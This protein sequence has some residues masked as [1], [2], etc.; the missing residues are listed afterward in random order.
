EYLTVE[1][2]ETKAVHDGT[3][4]LELA[5]SGDYDMAVLD[6]MLPKM[7]GFDVLRNLRGSSRLPVL[8]LTA[9][10]DDMERIV[11]LEIGADD[12]LPKP[13]NPRELVARLRA[14]LRRTEPEESSDRASDKIVVEDLE[15]SRSARTAKIG[16]DE[17]PLTS[18]EFDLLTHL[19]MEAGKVVRKDD[20]SESV[21]ERKLSP[22]DRS[23]DMHISNLRKKLG[24]RPDGSERIKTI[25]SVGYIYT[26]L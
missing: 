20:L 25:R 7:N 21:L 12:Y 26:V 14:I 22:Y 13:F 9:R 4:G 17:I 11:G 23:L 10:G 16:G 2:F 1:G 18:V 24:P 15:L 6:V 5:L 19:A 8:M 3:A